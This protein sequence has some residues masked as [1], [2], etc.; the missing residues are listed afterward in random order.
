[1]AI[2]TLTTDFGTVDGYVGAMKGVILS[3]A[4]GA[5]I[6]DLTHDVPPQDV[7]AAAFGLYRAVPFYPRES[8]HCVVV[9]PGVGT[10]RRPLAL[11][12][13]GGQLL[14]G[15]DS[16]VFT[17]L[18]P[19]FVEREP[20][21]VELSEPR[22]W[23]TPPL[24]LSA[25]FHGRDIFAPVAAHLARRLDEDGDVELSEFGKPAGDLA[26][27]DMPVP[28]ENRRGYRGEVVSVD[29]FGNAVTNLPGRWVAEAGA[30]AYVE[31]GDRGIP[32]IG[33]YGDIE[34]GDLCAL[35]NSSGWLEVAEREGSAAD[36]L[37][38]A[39]GIPVV[40]RKAQA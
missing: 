37:G 25:T 3:L 40:L 7:R 12:T 11:R 24:G 34:V 19:P 28:V 39:P 1:M 5:K 31:I 33:T 15:P 38:L 26:R 27:F 16:G 36:R 22:W 20:E 21:A 14:V 32:I 2:V 6:L 9:D 35:V 4:P 10:A 23:G 29:H 8:V 13:A 30:V 17:L 18:L